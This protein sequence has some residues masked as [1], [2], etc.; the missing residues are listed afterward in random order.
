MEP[1]R[2][3]GQGFSRVGEGGFEN[4][5]CPNCG[6]EEPHRRQVPCNSMKCPRCG[7][8]MIGD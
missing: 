7:T 5:K 8:F 4:C 6:Y 3:Q 2:G 1:G